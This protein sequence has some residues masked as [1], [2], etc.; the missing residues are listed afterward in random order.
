M[1]ISPP[2]DAER[3]PRAGGLVAAITRLRPL[4]L[5]FGGTFGSAIF[6]M[7]GQLL[8]A[9]SLSIADYGRL[10]AVL[11]AVNLLSPVAAFGVNWFW[12]Q[13]FGREGYRGYRWIAPSLSLLAV[14]NLISLAGLAVYF[15][16]F[17]GLP[18]SARLSVI[19][20]GGLMLLG[21]CAVEIASVKFQLEERFGLLALW[22]AVSQ[23][24]RFL[25]AAGLMITA[26]SSLGAVLLGYGL[27]GFLLLVFGLVIVSHFHQRKVRLTGHVEEAISNAIETAGIVV[28]AKQ[29]FPFAFITIFYLIYFQSVI[30]IIS[31]FL[32]PES[33]AVFS[34]A[35]LLMSAIHLV[36]NI[37]FTKFLMARICR[38]AEHDH[39][40]FEAILHVS[41]ASMLVLG[42]ATMAGVAIGASWFVPL[43]FG[44]KYAKSVTVLIWLS[45]TIP[46]RF[47][48]SAYSATLVSEANVRRRVKYAG[49]SAVAS[50]A[51]NF[52]LL[53]IF[54][55]AGAATAA[56]AS[57]L[58][59]L[60]LNAWGASRHV[61]GIRI[62]E[63]FR[64]SV[65]KT[66][67]ARI[68]EAEGGGK[69]S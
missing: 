52:A 24:G 36:P 41:V 61:D 16:F 4:I 58:L 37:V 31:A 6:A 39:R 2:S 49:L 3:E 55:L 33:T 8:L 28:T 43:V 69:P 40:S 50:L 56:V 7:A 1:S 13:I 22:Q 42:L 60:V 57:E 66:S 27:V 32:G 47:V 25:V 64:W 67:A 9:R 63:S 46:I 44:A 10:A 38:W 65:L 5:L 23:V 35:L 29:S 21:Q 30:L 34:A 18:A 53:P 12:V 19:G 26:T 59:L 54:G 48:Q 20:L 15:G 45:P 68:I 14:T 51:I 17:A 11:A 62:G